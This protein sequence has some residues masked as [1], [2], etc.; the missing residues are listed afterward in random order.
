MDKGGIYGE[1]RREYML[2]GHNFFDMFRRG[3]NIRNR[4]YIELAGNGSITFGKI[5]YQHYRVVYPIPIR[6]MN[7]NP[8][9][10]NQQNPGYADWVPG[11]EQ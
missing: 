5:S 6:E 2:E 8:Y 4:Q 1:R 9:I 7:A 10:R 11:G 3:D